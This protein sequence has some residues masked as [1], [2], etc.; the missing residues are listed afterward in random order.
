MYKRQHED[1]R[2]EAS[3]WIYDTLPPTSKI[4]TEFGNV[5]TLPIA[6]SNTHPNTRQPDFSR[7]EVNLY[8]IDSDVAES[9][10]LQTELSS[11]DY[12]VIASR[13]VFANFT[14]IWPGDSTQALTTKKYYQHGTYPSRCDAKESEFPLVSDFYSQLTDPNQFTLIKTFTSYPRL[15]LAGKTLMEFPDEHAEEALT[16]F[17]HPVVRIYQRK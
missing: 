15:T 17:D 7:A 11:S 14:C 4:L 1:V 16:V 6:D 3:K 2:L 9:Q 13:R 8:N 12:V 5:M 10:K